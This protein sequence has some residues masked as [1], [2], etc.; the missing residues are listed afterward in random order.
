L[1]PVWRWLV[2]GVILVLVAIMV[3]IHFLSLLLC[4]T[5]GLLLVIPVLAFGLSEPVNFST[6]KA[7][8]KLFGKLMGNRLAYS[9]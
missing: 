4:M 6:S 1:E 3:V 8:K 5:L 2:V 7:H 9:W